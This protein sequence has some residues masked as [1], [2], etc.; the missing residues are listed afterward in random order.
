MAVANETKQRATGITVAVGLLV[1]VFGFSGILSFE[2]DHL[3][4][5]NPVWFVGMLIIFAAALALISVVFRWLGLANPAEAFGLPTGSVR[6]LL[7]VAVMVL[8]AV[9]GLAAIGGDDKAPKTPAERLLSTA[10][11][12]TASADDEIKRYAAMN[13]AAIRES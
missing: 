13:I 8:F 7:A 5:S 9:F 6:A 3:P 10:V 1:V 2:P 11:V 12:A 4:K